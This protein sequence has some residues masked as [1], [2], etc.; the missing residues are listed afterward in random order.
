MEHRLNEERD[1]N[2][3]RVSKMQEEFENKMREEMADKEEE[4][5]CLQNEIRESE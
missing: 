5:E 2:S 1:R 3:H 4:I